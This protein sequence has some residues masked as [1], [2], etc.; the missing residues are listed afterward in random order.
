M[1]P[2][3]SRRLAKIAVPLHTYLSPNDYKKFANDAEHAG[4]FNKLSDWYKYLIAYIER[5]TNNA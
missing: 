1:S 5:E 4:T 3:L 2:E